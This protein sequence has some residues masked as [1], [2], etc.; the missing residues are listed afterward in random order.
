M[1]FFLVH[2]DLYLVLYAIFR[3]HIGV[4]LMS[5]NDSLN[6]EGVLKKWWQVFCVKV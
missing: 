2:R 3:F 6:C 1:R 5:C 4:K